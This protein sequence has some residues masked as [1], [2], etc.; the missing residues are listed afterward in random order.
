MDAVA[1]AGDVIGRA[2]HGAGD[3]GGALAAVLQLP[4]QVCP[5]ALHLYHLT[6]VCGKT[7]QTEGHQPFPFS[8]PPVL[9]FSRGSEPWLQKQESSILRTTALDLQHAVQGPFPG[10]QT[11]SPLAPLLPM[12]IPVHVSRE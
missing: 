12:H 6:G 5:K 8:P 3:T 2:A 10:S 7:K 4:R 1:A 11:P 9:H